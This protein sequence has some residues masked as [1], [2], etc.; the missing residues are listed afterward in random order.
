MFRDPYTYS[1]SQNRIVDAN[2]HPPSFPMANQPDTRCFFIIAKR[3]VDGVGELRVYRNW[4]DFV[5]DK[6]RCDKLRK[7]RNQVCNRCFKDDYGCDEIWYAEDGTI[8]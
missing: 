3:K 1:F 7:W 5:F 4:V 8:V 2:T 6:A